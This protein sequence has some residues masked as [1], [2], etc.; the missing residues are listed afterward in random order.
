LA[1]SAESPSASLA[2]AAP[3][4]LRCDAPDYDTPPLTRRSLDFD[5]DD[6]DSVFHAFMAVPTEAPP[7]PSAV[8]QAHPPSK[9]E[10]PWRTTTT[11]H[12]KVRGGHGTN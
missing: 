5:S 1:E 7:M 4:L 8:T 3:A 11:V 9:T 10:G 2:A 6:D 12:P